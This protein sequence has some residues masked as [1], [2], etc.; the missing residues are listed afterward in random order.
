MQQLCYWFQV[1]SPLYQCWVDK[2]WWWP[3][4]FCIVMLN[5]LLVSFSLQWLT[6]RR[7]DRSSPTGKIA[8][9][10]TV[11]SAC[12]WRTPAT[13]APSSVSTSSRL[14]PRCR[15]TI[16]ESP[17]ATT[18][19]KHKAELLPLTVLNKHPDMASSVFVL[20]RPQSLSPSLR[21]IMLVYWALVV[22]SDR[23]RKI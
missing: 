7:P 21:E 12:R 15:S 19:A 13:S 4:T 9:D 10:T 22:H 3:K 20:Q 18:D 5:S 16:V 1:I 6:V 23:L 17:G 11:P 2:S 8:H 14:R